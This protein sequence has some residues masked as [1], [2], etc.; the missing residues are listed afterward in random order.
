[1]P[2][3]GRRD[4]PALIAGIRIIEGADHDRSVGFCGCRNRTW[5]AIPGPIAVGPIG[6]AKPSLE[7]PRSCDPGTVVASHEIL[8]QKGDR[9]E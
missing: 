8:A 9:R 3:I 2:V 6:T 5:N 1:M 7:G 4:R